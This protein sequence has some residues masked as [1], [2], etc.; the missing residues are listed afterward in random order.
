LQKQYAEKGVTFIGVSAEEDEKIVSKFVTK[1]GDKM[2]Y[3]VAWDNDSATDKAYMQ[4]SE[5]E[6]IPAAFVVGKQGKIEW[7][8]HPMEMD[9][10][11]AKVVD[12]TWDAKKY[13]EDQ[14]A[15]AELRGG[16]MK[17]AR[18]GDTA[19]LAKAADAMETKFPGKDPALAMFVYDKYME[20]GKLAEA[21]AWA[22]KHADGAYKDSDMLLNAF[23]WGMVDPEKDIKD[24]DLDAALA[25]ATKASDLKKN[26]DPMILDTLAR[27]HFLKGD[28][29]KAVELQTK[30]VSLAPDEMKEELEKSLA[31]FKK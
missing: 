26:E 28:K 18:S 24:R 23:A 30:A 29:A 3:V 6:G 20:E 13:A 31:E 8:G 14:K 22:T 7:I 9:D 4:A 21:K 16:V 2:D 19:A 1:Q 12:G 11:I 27:V 10:V 17:A 5:Q 15:I 25:W